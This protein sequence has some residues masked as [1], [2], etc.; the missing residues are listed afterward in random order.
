MNIVKGDMPPVLGNTPRYSL[1]E[2]SNEWMADSGRQVVK[3]EASMKPNIDG[4][5]SMVGTNA[6]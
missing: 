4:H 5:A 2:T 3:H 1:V 6:F